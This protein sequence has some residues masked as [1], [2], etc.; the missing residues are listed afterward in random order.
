MS[1]GYNP[2]PIVKQGKNVHIVGDCKK[3]G[4]LRTVIW[5]VW[6]TVMKI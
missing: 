4:N 3:V 1:I 5:S 6:D 2:S